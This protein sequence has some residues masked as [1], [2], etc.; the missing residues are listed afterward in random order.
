MIV[1]VAMSMMTPVGIVMAHV[2]FGL[3]PGVVY[4]GMI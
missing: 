3:V 1:V 2:V 4:D